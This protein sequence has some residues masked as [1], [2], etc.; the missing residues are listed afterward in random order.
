[1]NIWHGM[2][3]DGYGDHGFLSSWHHNHDHQIIFFHL[4]LLD[5]FDVGG[6]PAW[7]EWYYDDNT[8][9]SVIL[10]GTSVIQCRLTFRITSSSLPKRITKQSA[11]LYPFFFSPFSI[12]L[13]CF[14]EDKMDWDEIYILS[15]VWG[16]MRRNVITTCTFFY[17]QFMLCSHCCC[18]LFVFLIILLPFFCP[19]VIDNCQSNLQRNKI[20]QLGI[21]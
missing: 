13:L 20:R 21:T 3:W 14:R 12:Y 2:G 18:C 6:E 16:V 9:Y 5:K 11:L 17:T 8:D 1:M 4:V 19:L 15:I 10:V 7:P